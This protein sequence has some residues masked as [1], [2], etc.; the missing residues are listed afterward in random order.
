MDNNL[1]LL[2]DYVESRNVKLFKKLG[3][4]AKIK[5]DTRKFYVACYYIARFACDMMKH[6]GNLY[7]SSLLEDTK[8]VLHIADGNK[9]D[10]NDLLEKVF[11]PGYTNSNGESLGLSLAIAK[12]NIESLNGSINLQSSES[13]TSYLISIPVSS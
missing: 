2:S 11:D 3:E 9:I 1:T 12:F 6:G 8:V 13:G 5:V 7:F 10:K 4:D